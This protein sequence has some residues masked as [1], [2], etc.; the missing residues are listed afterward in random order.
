MRQAVLP[1]SLLQ[2]GMIK[3]V[4]LLLLF[5]RMNSLRVPLALALPCYSECLD[6]DWRLVDQL[7][8]I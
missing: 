2:A 4:E 1:V 7:C 6:F 8:R 3:C 5:L